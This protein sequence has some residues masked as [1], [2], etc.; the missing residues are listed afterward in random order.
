MKNLTWRT[1]PAVGQVRG[2][3][4]RKRITLA[5]SVATT[6]GS[7]PNP[8]SSPTLPARDDM[9][10]RL[11][12]WGQILSLFSSFPAFHFCHLKRVEALYLPSSGL[13]ACGFMGPV[14]MGLV[15]DTGGLSVSGRSAPPW[16]FDADV[17]REGFPPWSSREALL[18]WGAFICCC[19]CCCSEKNLWVDWRTSARCLAFRQEE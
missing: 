1:P 19:C 10:L 11:S 5:T 16:W 8:S 2:R 17:S 3:K 18:T 6:S 9:R 14:R 12:E 13:M 7:L 15:A 4:K